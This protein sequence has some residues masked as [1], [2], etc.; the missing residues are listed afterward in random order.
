MIAVE[1]SSIVSGMRRRAEFP[2]RIQGSCFSSWVSARVRRTPWLPMMSGCIQPAALFCQVKNTKGQKQAHRLERSTKGLRSA[3]CD[4]QEAPVPAA[5]SLSVQAGGLFGDAGLYCASLQLRTKVFTLAWP[6]SAK[7][8]IMRI[9]GCC[10]LFWS[11]FWP[12]HDGTVGSG[13]ASF[14]ISHRLFTL[15]WLLMYSF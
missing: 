3:F 2:G 11:L 14:H 15:K 12:W 1:N 13:P 4:S 5:L 6:Q 8:L 9:F 7:L 10:F